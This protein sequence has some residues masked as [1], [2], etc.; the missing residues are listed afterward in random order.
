MKVSGVGQLN[1]WAMRTNFSTKWAD[2]LDMS[3]G[4]NYEDG[5]FRQMT[6]TG[7]NPDNSSLTGNVNSTLMA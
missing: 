5:D 4:L 2:L 7:I 1:G 6:E 3:A